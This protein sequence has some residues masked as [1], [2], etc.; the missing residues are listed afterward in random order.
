MPVYSPITPSVVLITANVPP[1]TYHCKQEDSQ[2]SIVHCDHTTAL[3]R[4]Q[5]RS[6]AVVSYTGVSPWAPITLANR[7][8]EGCAC[9]L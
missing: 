1:L 2:A 4:F 9:L 6:I 7:R 3:E 8:S 5:N